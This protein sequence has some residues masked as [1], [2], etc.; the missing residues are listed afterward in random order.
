MSTRTSFTPTQQQTVSMCV[1][2]RACVCARTCA[3][4][5][6]LSV[7]VCVCT[8]AVTIPLHLPPSDLWAKPHMTG[9]VP[10][11]R[12]WFSFTKT[13]VRTA[14]VFGGYVEC[15]KAVNDIYVLNMDEWVCTCVSVTTS[16]EL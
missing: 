9:S 10:D 16:S 2:T 3:C 5:C 15:H 13:D 8:H 1:R 6:E 11:G 12:A 14:V 7:C 4:V